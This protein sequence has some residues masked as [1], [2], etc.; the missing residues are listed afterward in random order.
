MKLRFW[1]SS[2][3]R[4]FNT[5]LLTILTGRSSGFCFRKDLFPETRVTDFVTSTSVSF[6]DALK[7]EFVHQ[8]L[9]SFSVL[10]DYWSKQSIK[11]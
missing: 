4:Y 8:V 3:L 11:A 6:L 10:C 5:F 7:V 9:R 1:S 2:P